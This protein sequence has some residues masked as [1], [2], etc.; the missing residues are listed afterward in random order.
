[1]AQYPAILQPQISRQWLL[2]VVQKIKLWAGRKF[3]HDW[4]RLM[5]PGASGS[6]LTFFSTWNN[7]PICIPKL[8]PTAYEKSSWG[9]K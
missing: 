3:Y 7:H 1:M 4:L 9:K 5:S 2:M 6:I 8:F